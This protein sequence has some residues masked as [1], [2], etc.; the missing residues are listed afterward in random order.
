MEYNRILAITGMPGLYELVSSKTDGAIVKSLEDKSVKF[1]SSRVHNF[2]HLESIE[3]YTV[4]ENV[5]LIDVLKAMEASSELI[6]SDKDGALVKTYLQKVYPDLD[7]ERVYSSDL[8]KMVKWYGILKENNIEIKFTRAE[9]DTEAHEAGVDGNPGGEI[10]PVD[11]LVTKQIPGST[12]Q[13]GHSQTSDQMIA[14]PEMPYDASLDTAIP[15]EEEK[16]REG[17]L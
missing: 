8:K 10:T 17:L 13:P 12:A 3:V 14:T 6:P 15:K 2:S 11:D 4:R 5:N 1:V 16:K 7:F 9:E